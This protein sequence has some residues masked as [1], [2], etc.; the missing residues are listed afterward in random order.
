MK[1]NTSTLT[2]TNH[3][4]VLNNLGALVQ[5]RLK[6]RGIILARQQLLSMFTNSQDYLTKSKMLAE[7]LIQSI[8]ELR[9]GLDFEN[10]NKTIIAA[11]YDCLLTVQ[12]NLTIDDL[13]SCFNYSKIEKKPFSKMTVDEFML[14]VHEY[15]KNKQVARICIQEEHIAH[16]KEIAQA[17]AAE[18][19]YLG[20]KALY[21]ES[22]KA[23]EWKGDMFQARVIAKKFYMRLKEWHD[24]IKDEAKDAW[25]RQKHQDEERVTVTPDKLYFL[26]QSTVSKAVEFGLKWVEA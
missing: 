23:G 17:E 15:V 11:I 26:A 22:L 8:L 5:E 10:Q 18:Q 9:Y 12:E 25:L 21:F 2:S 20:A 1:N 3:L 14:P 19:F 13:R 6:S 4:E 7:S 16:V 24:E